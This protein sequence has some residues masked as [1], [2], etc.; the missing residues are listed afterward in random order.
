M[1]E[2]NHH[3]DYSKTDLYVSDPV[4]NKDTITSF[5]TYNLKGKIITEIL[6]RRY[7]DFDALRSKL[8]ENWPGVYIPNIPHKQAVGA[9]N[10]EV[11]EMRMEQINRFL[12]KLSQL[13]HLFNSDE[14][15]QFL[16]DT[17]DTQKSI[18]SM[19]N[20]SYGEILIKYH[21]LFTDYN[22]VS[23]FTCNKKLEF[24]CKSSQ[25]RSL[26]ISSSFKN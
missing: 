15:S 6:V 19:P 3:T 17:P 5:V 22:E 18:N 25:S 9:N 11:I 23:N 13:P 2:I 26:S 21:K 10:R 8:M 4:V 16:K 12:L 7:R 20:Q 24:R 14:L 1:E